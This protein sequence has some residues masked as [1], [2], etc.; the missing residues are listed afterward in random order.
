MLKKEDV[1]THFTSKLDARYR[2]D[3]DS[4]FYFNRNQWRYVDRINQSIT[5]Y[6]KPV[7]VEED[8]EVALVFKDRKIGQTLHIM[9]SDEE[10]ATLIGVVMYVRDSIDRV[11]IVHLVLHE[12]CKII[13]KQDKINILGIVLDKVLRLI[14]K[15]KGVET[16]RIYYIDKEFKLEQLLKEPVNV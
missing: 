1:V 5:D 11:T 13:Y 12:N 14:T 15:L 4:L 2:E 3:L 9:D 10:D 16:V 6:S 7:V 8:G